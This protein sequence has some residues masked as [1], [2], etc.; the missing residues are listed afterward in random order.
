MSTIEYFFPVRFAGVDLEVESWS[1]DIGR[2]VIVH[3]P[4]RG[5]GAELSDRGRVPRQ[6]TWSVR[7]TGTAL[8]VTDKRAALVVLARTGDTRTLEHPLD[9]IVRCKLETLTGMVAAGD[10]GFEM[11]LI[12]DL[13]FT[14][15]FPQEDSPD[16]GTFPEV[17]IR[18][19]EA[20]EAIEILATPP[21]STVPD[22]DAA[23]GQ[24]STWE[25]RAQGD[26]VQDVEAFRAEVGDLVRELDR[27]SDVEAYQAA[28][29]VEAFRAVYEQYS[30]TVNDARSATFDLVLA[31]PQPL[32][33]LLSGIYG[34]QEA[35]LFTEEVARINDIRDVIR[36]PSG[37]LLT[38]PQRNGR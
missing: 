3:R 24:A 23:S 7:L 4:S 22:F 30:Q 21:E 37:F 36:L 10:V 38:L 15:R 8:Q 29:S 16:L 19:S 9:G 5:D 32:I 20:T 13:A 6:Y 14:R 28:V 1:E 34:A 33:T 17:E 11:V 2:T 18:A 31:R 27:T 25:E 12:E 35:E 26:I